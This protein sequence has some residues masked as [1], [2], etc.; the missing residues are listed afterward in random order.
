MASVADSSSARGDGHVEPRLGKAKNSVVRVDQEAG[1]VVNAS[2]SAVT[3]FV[4]STLRGAGEI[5]GEVDRRL[6]RSRLVGRAWPYPHIVNGMSAVSFPADASGPASLSWIQGG[7][8][9]EILGRGGQTLDDLQQPPRLSALH[10]YASL[11]RM[12]ARFE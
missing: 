5:T 7:C 10:G 12:P 1:D 9:V 3:D 4:V 11:R 8:K 2:R 6:R